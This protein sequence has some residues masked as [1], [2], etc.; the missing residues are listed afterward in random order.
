MTGIDP[1]S[2]AAQAI[3]VASGELLE[4]ARHLQTV[5]DALKL[6]EIVKELRAKLDDVSDL[7]LDKADSLCGVPRVIGTIT[8]ATP[9]GI[10]HTEGAA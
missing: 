2:H 1:V 7:A 9:W 5:Q 6:Y 4:V 10:S 3:H 8:P